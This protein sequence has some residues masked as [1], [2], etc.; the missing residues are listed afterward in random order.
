MKQCRLPILAFEYNPKEK[1]DI[2]LSRKKYLVTLE[3]PAQAAK[4]RC[5]G[6]DEDILYEDSIMKRKS[7]FL[8]SHT[9]INL[10]AFI[11]FIVVMVHLIT[12]V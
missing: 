5:S 6:D 4:R 12:Y 7:V 1:G 8:F 9:L 2:G 10:S 3:E 11:L